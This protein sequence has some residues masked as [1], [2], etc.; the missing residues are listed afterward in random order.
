MR[1][2][3][4]GIRP[5]RH[6][7]A[8][9]LHAC[10]ATLVEHAGFAPLEALGAGWQF[11]YQLGDI[12]SE[13]YYFPCPDGR[14]LLSSL[15]PWHPISSRWHWPPDAEQGWHQVR[16]HLLAGSPAA[17]A[18][19]NFELPFRPAYQDVHSNHLVVVYGFD[20]ERR[21][22]LV[23]DAIPPFFQ[24]EL[25]LS[26]LAAARESGNRVTHERDMFFA[27]NPIGNRWLQLLSPGSPGTAAGPPGTAAGPPGSAAGPPGSA[28]GPPGSA[29]GSPAGFLAGNLKG[30]QVAAEPGSYRGRDGIAEF[31]AEMSNRL[32]GGQLIADELFVVAGAA[33]ASTAVHAD[34][35]A[36]TGRRLGLAGWPELARQIT[37]VAHHW[38]AIRILASLSRSGEVS[39]QRLRSRRAALLADLDRALA[40]V[41][42][43]LTGSAH[44]GPVHSG[45][46]HSGS[47]HKGPVHSGSANSG[48]AHSD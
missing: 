36:D 48:S 20:D 41:E 6:D 13:E 16:E 29:G 1:V 14:S 40:E 12:R 7:L 30:F 4:D 43:V 9:C 38:T 25:P 23:L 27:D 10:A 3:L 21:S 22:A 32:E 35:V 26:V 2:E 42:T 33:L 34:W 45:P 44:S 28:A 15:A 18:V 17:V 11:Y 24:G 5:W 37:R 39:A 31:L 47:A 46:V 8:G 19:D